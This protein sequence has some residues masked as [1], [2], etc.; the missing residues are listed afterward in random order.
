MDFAVVRG[1]VTLC[2]VVGL[3]GQVGS[4]GLSGIIGIG[5][6]ASCMLGCAAG[7][8][9]CIDAPPRLVFAQGMPCVGSLCHSWA[10]AAAGGCC[11]AH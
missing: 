4:C 11:S 6:P 5:L 10:G 3:V 2:A 1:V 8:G 9:I 7:A